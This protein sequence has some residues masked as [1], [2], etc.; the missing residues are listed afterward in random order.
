MEPE[1]TRVPQPLEYEG[2]GGEERGGV[3]KAMEN[4]APLSLFF[5]S[6]DSPVL[7]EQLRGTSPLSG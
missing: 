6:Q 7:G 1:D 5:L 3:L 4:R 2:E